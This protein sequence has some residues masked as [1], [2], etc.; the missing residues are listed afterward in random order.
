MRL[1]I[2]RLLSSG[3]F[4]RTSQWNEMHPFADEIGPEFGGL[5]NW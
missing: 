1:Q 2:R 3:K 5:R 4:R